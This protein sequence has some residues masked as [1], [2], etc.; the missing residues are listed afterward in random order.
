MSSTDKFGPLISRLREFNRDITDHMKAVLT[1]VDVKWTSKSQREVAAREAKETVDKL[2]G[3]A[4]KTI[5]LFAEKDWSIMEDIVSFGCR[6][7]AHFFKL[8]KL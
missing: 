8:R 7:G 3:S 2:Y 4:G 1:I 6:I 5:R